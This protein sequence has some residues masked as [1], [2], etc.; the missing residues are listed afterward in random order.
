MRKHFSYCRCFSSILAI[1][2]MVLM[3]ITVPST[4]VLAQQ[5]SAKAETSE[6]SLPP[7]PPQPL[8][9][10]EKAEKDGNALRM[11]LRELTKMALQNN[12]EIAI[13]DANEELRKQDII[14][15]FGQYDPSI[16][17]SI[18]FQ[19]SKDPN[20]NVATRSASGS[21]SKTD[22]INW[23]V[24]FNQN[25]KTGGNFVARYNSSRRDSDQGFFLFNPIYSTGMTFN[26]TQPLLRNF[27][28]D[29][30]RGQIK[31]ANL[32]LK[33]ND[34]QFKQKV[35]N[36]IADIQ[37]RY[38][39]LVGAIRNYEIKRESVKLAQISLRDNMRKVEVGTLASINVVESQATLAQ[40]E[41]ELVQAE[42]MVYEAENTLLTL[43]CNDKKADLWSKIIIPTET[44][45]FR[46]YKVD[47]NLAIEEALK[48]RPELEQAGIDLQKN[49][50]NQKIRQDARKW[51]VDLTTSFGTKGT[52]GPQVLGRDLITG[53]LTEM[54]PPDIVGGYG[55][56]H[57]MLFTGGFTNW[58]VGFDLQVPLRNRSDD[59]QLA[60]L[61]IEN[62]QQLMKRMNTEQ[63]IQAEIRN[64]VRKIEADAMQVVAYGASVKSAK[65]QYIGE[66]KRFEGGLS[67]NYLVLDYQNKFSEA[68]YRE[69]QVLI[70]H[71]K[72]IISLK[73]AMYTLLESNDFAI[74]KTAN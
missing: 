10:T 57:K 63:Q 16:T 28:I 14:Q 34:S 23:D 67:Q 42:Q 61:K 56:G 25:V 72:S 50:I 29:Q 5:A 2:C 20:T 53:Q 66:Q 60:K 3:L 6:T 62:R 65:E 4:V 38:W 70:N 30:T 45:E 49:E 21:F 24:S 51:K 58:S 12:L 32:D 27:R 8:S 40:K 64:A 47:L 26:F 43:V 52:A 1:V 35:V 9:P 15:V 55:N 54:T 19:S 46:E 18:G 69:L 36:T 33:T 73:K 17:S 68:Q 41:G 39:D 22:M 44:P 71:K 37:G 48:N 74:V 7:I 31:I 11:S 59:A 13:Q